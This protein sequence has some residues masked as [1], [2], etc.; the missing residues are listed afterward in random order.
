MVC[1]AQSATSVR[2]PPKIPPRPP[3]ADL[4]IDHAIG[5]YLDTLIPR[6]MHESTLIRQGN[7]LRRFFA[8]ALAE[9]LRTLSTE[10]LQ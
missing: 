5:L 8:P 9:P 10:R 3:A 6:G 2:R 4:T 7:L 1:H